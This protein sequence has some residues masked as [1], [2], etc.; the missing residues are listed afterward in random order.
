MNKLKIGFWGGCFNPPS[1]I[2]I[3]LAKNLLKDGFL[4]KLV[5]VPVGDYF[6]KTDLV[7]AKDRYNMLKIACKGNNNL[8]V[9][10]IVCNSTK[11]LYAIDTIKLLYEK[12]KDNFECFFVMGADNYEKLPLWKG[13]NE[14]INQY[15]FI[16]IERLNYKEIIN[17]ENVVV[18]KNNKN[19]NDISST[20]IRKLIKD[21]KNVDQYLNVDVYDY[22]K[23]HNLYILKR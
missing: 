9:E 23:K 13:Y 18:F 10:D 16:V 22:I 15:K 4:D 1:N 21:G 12:Y 3:N 19:E 5:F 20:D 14:L 8:E 6:N 2:H 17:T 11:K 7:A